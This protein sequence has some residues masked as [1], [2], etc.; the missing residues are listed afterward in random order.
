MRLLVTTQ[1]PDFDAAVDPRFGRAAWFVLVDTGT[2]AW[3]SHNNPAVDAPS[4]AGGRAAEFV[5]RLN[6]QAIISGAFGPNA[7][8]ALRAAGIGM[9]LSRGSCTAR[10]A[11]ADFAAGKL[12]RAD[13]ASG[14]R[15]H[16]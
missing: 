3:E 5:T 6:A 13:A 14:P 7:F 9:Y 8:A 4:G 2:L 11:V 1:E 16:G 12:E 15:G 10:Q